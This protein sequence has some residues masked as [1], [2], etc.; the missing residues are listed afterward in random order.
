MPVA[1]DPAAAPG[2]TRGAVEAIVRQALREEP[3]TTEGLHRLNAQ[4]HA[5]S[6]NQ[7]RKL[8][9]SMV[10]LARGIQTQ[11]EDRTDRLLESLAKDLDIKVAQAVER[12]MSALAAATPGNGM[13]LDGGLPEPMERAVVRLLRDSRF[14]TSQFERLI[15]QGAEIEA[16]QERKREALGESFDRRLADLAQRVEAQLA[17]LAA[18]ETPATAAMDGKIESLRAGLEGQL[19]RLRQDL[20]QGLEEGRSLSRELR[21]IRREMALLGSAL[22]PEGRRAAM[23]LTA[24]DMARSIERSLDASA[25]ALVGR[26]ERLMLSL[27]AAQP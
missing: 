4:W 26:I 12:R 25:A 17:V 9:E 15:A 22:A 13:T 19:A 1:P 11:L 7:E 2:L 6:A 21:E 23:D 18:P 27:S 10:A 5:N 8:Q 24:D 14:T 16:A 3:S 20:Q